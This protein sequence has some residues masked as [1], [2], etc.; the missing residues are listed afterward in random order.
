MSNWPFYN[1]EQLR[2]VNKVVKSN[3]V[4]YWT[5]NESKQFE[6]EFANK[7]G[8][9]HAVTVANGTLALEIALKTLNLKSTDEVIVTPRSYIASAITV[10]NIGAIPIFADIDINSQNIS[11]ETIKNKI[12]KRTKAI[13][14]V[15]LAGFPCDM[16]DIV[17]YSK[18]N[19]IKIIEDCSQAH[20]SKINNKY[21]GSFGDISTW[22]FCNDKIISTLGE[23]GMI[24]TNNT[25]FWKKI[26]SLKDCGKNYES[27]FN[28][29]HPQGFRWVHDFSGT[30][31]RLT[32]VQSAIGRYQLKLLD[33]WT[34]IRNNYSN[35][36]WN[37][38]SGI[39][40]VRIPRIPK[41]YIHSSYRCNVL[42]N[43]KHL[44][45]GYTRDKILDLLEK[46]KIKC[47]VGSCPEIYNEKIFKKIKFFPKK[48]LKN[49]KFVGENSL[50][51]LVHPTITKNKLLK[52]TDIIKKILNKISK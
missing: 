35:I 52:D 9:K 41:N 24:G 43:P 51:F 47:F 10:Y 44:K 17:K 49:A 50:S 46:N 14:C 39:K 23:G 2:I 34:R 4:N 21:V 6:K 22:S 38:L 11:L 8:L 1:N 25:N 40:A 19:K 31:A 33:K 15:H 37:K 7:I 5:G 29:K 28:K 16:I 12:S 26:W 32:E 27:V 36:I 45:K 20:G 18:K 13:I 3:K 42:L 48:R 30:N